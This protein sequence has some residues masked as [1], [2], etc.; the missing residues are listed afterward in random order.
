VKDDL[1]FNELAGYVRDDISADPP[2]P[3]L[4]DAEGKEDISKRNPRFEQWCATRKID[5]DPC[6][7]KSLGFVVDFGLLSMAN[8]KRAIPL[9]R[10][11]L[12]ASN[13][14]MV[15]IAVASLA[16]LNDTASIPSIA[17]ACARLSPQSAE[18]V[19]IMAGRFD[20][21]AV[22][23]LLNQYVRDP[24]TRENVKKE[25]LDRRSK[26]EPSSDRKR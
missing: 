15:L 7:G 14:A 16:R 12:G 21:P 4:L 17:K 19:A 5:F 1:Y 6:T 26:T 11:A 23:G 25:W 10:L 13:S 8:D 20:D 2:E 3:Y 22:V 24:E 9:L 18:E